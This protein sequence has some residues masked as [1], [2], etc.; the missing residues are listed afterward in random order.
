MKPG[1]TGE[2]RMVSLAMLAIMAGCAA[3]L[4]LKGTLAQGIGM[5]F[6]ALVAGLVAFGFFEIASKYLINYSPG[7]PPGRRWPAF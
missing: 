5:I 7:W 2:H 4:Y 6:N 3:G 1:R